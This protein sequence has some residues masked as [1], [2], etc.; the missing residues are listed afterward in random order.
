MGTP[1][2]ANKNLKSQQRKLKHGKLSED[3]QPATKSYV[4]VGENE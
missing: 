1:K 4:M 2:K 3:V